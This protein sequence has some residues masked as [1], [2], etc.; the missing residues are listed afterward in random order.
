MGTGNSIRKRGK[1]RPLAL[2][3][4]ED[5]PQ[6]SKPPMNAGGSSIEEPQDPGRK[7]SRILQVS[8]YRHVSLFF[9]PTT[10]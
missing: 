7:T 4:N 10:P 9:T 1:S 6:E 2:A 3:L 8:G 5:C